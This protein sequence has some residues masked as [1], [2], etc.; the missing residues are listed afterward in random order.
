MLA[1]RFDRRHIIMAGSA[2][3]GSLSVVLA[4]VAWNGNPPPWALV[5]IVLGIGMANALIAP[6]NGALLPTWWT[7]GTCPVRSRSTRLR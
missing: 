3:Q 5:L 6:S 1:D 2:V 4:I 7:A